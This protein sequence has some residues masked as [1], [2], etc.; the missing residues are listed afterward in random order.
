[1]STFR[2]LEAKMGPEGNYKIYRQLEFEAK[3]PFIPFF[4]ILFHFFPFYI[5]KQ[6]IY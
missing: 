4:G 2:E 6:F 5:F 3:P 1:M